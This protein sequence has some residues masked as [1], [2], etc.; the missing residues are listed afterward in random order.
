MARTINK[1]RMIWNDRIRCTVMITKLVER[2]KNKCELYFPEELAV[3]VEFNNITVTVIHINYF[4]DYE[5]R[6]LKVV[7]RNSIFNLS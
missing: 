7:V 4:Q 3:P 1:N 2:N 5:R 6:Q